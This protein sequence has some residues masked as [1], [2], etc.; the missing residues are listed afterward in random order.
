MNDKGWISLHRRI[1]DNW[2]WNDKPFNRGAA[3]VDMLLMASYQ[4]TTIMFNH[5]PVEIKKGSFVTSSRKLADRWGWS[6]GKLERFLTELVDEQMIT[7]NVTAK[8]TIITIVNYSDFQ[9]MQTTKK[10]T[11][12]PQ[13][14][15]VIEPQTDLSLIHI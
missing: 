9:E 4:D 12:E 10:A 5:N 3:W 2:V 14:E 13:T 15:P 1:K 7:Q 11:N 6:R 8:Q